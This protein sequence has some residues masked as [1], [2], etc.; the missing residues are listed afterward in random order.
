MK[1]NFEAFQNQ[2]ILLC[3]A[4]LRVRG[5][6][7]ILVVPCRVLRL[8]S[9]TWLVSK[10][11]LG[12]FSCG[13]RVGG[14]AGLGFYPSLPEALLPRTLGHHWILLA[15]CYLT[16]V[17]EVSAAVHG[18][19]LPQRHSGRSWSG[20]PARRLLPSHLC[21][22]LLD[23]FKPGWHSHNKLY[24]LSQSV[25]RQIVCFSVLRAWKV[26]TAPLTQL[27]EEQNE[28]KKIPVVIQS[29]DTW[30]LSSHVPTGGTSPLSKCKEC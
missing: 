2:A 20:F 23:G 8:Y 1:C 24:C 25:F 6:Y 17:P 4:Q 27:Q 14:C 16:L 9:L 15:N 11:I 10:F 30:G 7:F 26:C 22:D 18:A 28:N 13:E 5:I 29:P 21:P 19:C 3:L 12:Q